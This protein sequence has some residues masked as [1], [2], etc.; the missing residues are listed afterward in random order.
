MSMRL[1]HLRERRYK[2]TLRSSICRSRSQCWTLWGAFVSGLG[3]GI[4][5]ELCRGQDGGETAADYLDVKSAADASASEV[6]QGTTTSGDFVD[7]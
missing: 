3:S 2:S 4:L 7:W 1:E 6:E 5:R